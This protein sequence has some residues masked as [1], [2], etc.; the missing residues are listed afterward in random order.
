M[1]LNE[2][3]LSQHIENIGYTHEGQRVAG[4]FVDGALTLG[5]KAPL[6]LSDR[7]EGRIDV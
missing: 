7:S 4:V 6:L 3:E 5:G 1:G 2:T